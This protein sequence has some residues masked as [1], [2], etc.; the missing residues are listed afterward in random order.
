MKQK[1]SKPMG[2]DLTAKQAHQ[3]AKCQKTLDIDIDPRTE[4]PHLCT[5]CSIP[6]GTIVWSLGND[7]RLNFRLRKFGGLKK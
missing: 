1:L 5:F 6:D 7:T 2:G 3:C 4:G